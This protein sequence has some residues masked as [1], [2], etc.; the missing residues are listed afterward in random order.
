MP[1]KFL[2]EQSAASS[3]SRDPDVHDRGIVLLLDE[4]FQTPAVKA[5]FPPH[6][7]QAKQ[8]HS[9]Q[10]LWQLVADFWQKFEQ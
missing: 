3:R 7:C 4:R 2:H 10:Q 6:W 5:L 1:T 9:N 8:A